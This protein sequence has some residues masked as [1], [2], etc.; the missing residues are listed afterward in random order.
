M[1]E[2]SNFIL[3][4]TPNGEVQLDILL[5]DENLWLTQKGIAEL[6]GVTRSTVSEHLANIYNDGE[7][8]KMATVRKFRTVSKEGNRMITRNMDYSAI[9]LMGTSPEVILSKIE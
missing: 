6:F 5:Q 3:Y 4:T 2:I 8:E 7:L 9:T 1:N